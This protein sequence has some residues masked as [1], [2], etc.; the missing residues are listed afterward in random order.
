MYY[1]LDGYNL[2]FTLT[3][4]KRTLATQRQN[5][6]GFL[7]RQ[8]ALRKMAGT[9]VFDGSI[10]RGEESGRSYPSPLEVVY[11]PKGQT[12]DAYILEEIE[13]AKNRR[14]C[15]VVTND[16]GLTRQ[17]RA[18]QAK[19]METAAFIQWLQKRKTSPSKKEIVETQHHF[20][21]LLKAFEEKLKED[22]EF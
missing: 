11:T 15:T 13:S 1:Y 14:Q 20:E 5:V 2:L 8:F 22:E 17:A 21:R 3:D 19:T 9:L 7:Q 12:A 6:I 10:R 16:K 4:S 18:L